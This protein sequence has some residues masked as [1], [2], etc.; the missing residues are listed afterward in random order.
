M[1]VIKV[2]EK[3]IFYNKN[4]NFTYFNDNMRQTAKI[5]LLLKIIM[6][7]RH[8]FEYLLRLHVFFWM[9]KQ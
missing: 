9:I 1:H 2:I 6:K 8:L 5:I 4:Y 3:Q 7:F